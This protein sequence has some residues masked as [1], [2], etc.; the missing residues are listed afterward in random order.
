[1]KLLNVA[2]RANT[3]PTLHL[4]TIEILSAGAIQSQGRRAQRD[5]TQLLQLP[6]IYNAADD[7][8]SYTY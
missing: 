5:S 3:P 4:G 2:S 8:E 1:M 7:H 6:R